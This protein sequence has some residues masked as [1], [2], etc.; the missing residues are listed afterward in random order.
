MLELIV[1]ITA[2]VLTSAICSLLEAVLYSVPVSYVEALAEEGRKSGLILRS[3]RRDVERPIAAILSLNTIANAAGAA[4]AG[5]TVVSLFGHQ[6]LVWFSAGFTVLIILLSE[7]LPKTTGVVFSR[8]LAPLIARPLQIMVW[9]L[10]PM[11]WLCMGVTRLVRRDQGE[12]QVSASD[13]IGMTRLGVKSGVLHVDEA[14]VIQNMLRLESR[15]ASDVMTH[16]TLMV[17]L[18]AETTVAEVKD[19]DDVLIY[20]RIPVFGTDI[21]DIV[22]IVHRRD[23]LAAAADDRDRVRME[24]L[25]K[26]VHFVLDTTPLDEVLRLLLDG[27]RQLFVVV[28][29]HG[30]VDGII[31]LEDL[32]EEILGREID[33]EFDEE[34]DKR[35]LARSRREHIMKKMVREPEPPREEQ[36]VP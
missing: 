17:S 13:L 6:W 32:M 12:H 1:I 16:R 8:R 26:P 35:A 29:K 2:A 28:D 27:G 11:V 24:E 18:D 25:V 7:I 23:I 19:R 36:E 21:D 4:L 9:L 31:A 10:T 34:A 33:D 5:A 15:T 14:S 30:G 3:L 20:S 22:G